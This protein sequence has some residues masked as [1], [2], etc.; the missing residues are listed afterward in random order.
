MVARR[1]CALKIRPR[2]EAC[3]RSAGSPTA[4]PPTATRRTGS[5]PTTTTAPASGAK[6]ADV[7]VRVLNGVG[8]AGL[9]AKTATSLAGAGYV[10]ADKGDAPALAPKTT[11]T[12]GAGQL[13]K[14]QSVQSTLLGPA[15]L[16]EDAT[17]KTV[18]VNL[19]L[20]ADFTGLKPTVGAAAPTTAA[21][22]S[23]P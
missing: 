1:R 8:T 21:S 23:P 18:D 20:G 14:A 16:R 15:I 11:I 19:L 13:A 7:K 3:G 6:P 2:I 5:W 4:S 9:A 12:Y 17:L 10:V 22:R